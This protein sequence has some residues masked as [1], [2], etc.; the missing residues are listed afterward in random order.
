MTDSNYI[1]CYGETLF[2]AECIKQGS[3]L[4]SHYWI[5]AHMIAL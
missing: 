3:L 2:F 5:Q 4:V 1:G